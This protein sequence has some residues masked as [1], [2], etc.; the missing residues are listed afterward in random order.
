MRA[1]FFKIDERKAIAWKRGTRFFEF[2]PERQ[3]IR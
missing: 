1:N 3:T 2:E